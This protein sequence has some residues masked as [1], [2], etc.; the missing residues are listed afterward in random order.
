[1]APTEPRW[2]YEANAGLTQRL[3]TPMG[4]VYGAI[5]QRRYQSVQPYQSKLPVICIGNFTAG[6]TG[7]TPFTQHLVEKLLANERRPCILTRGYGGRVR[8]VHWVDSAHDTAA[9]VGDEPLLLS[10]TAPVLVSL[11][12]AA[13]AREIE[14]SD[15][16]FTH[17]LMDDGLQN[18][19]LKKTLALAIVDG[20]RGIGNAR[21]M[22]AGPL[23]AP[24]QF[25]FGLADAI[26]VNRGFATSPIQDD[27][28]RVLQ[29]FAGPIF[30]AHIAPIGGQGWLRERPVVAFAGIAAPAHF[31]EMLRAIGA[32]I[33]EARPFGDHHTFTESDAAQLLKSAR[34][35]KAQLVTTEKDFVRLAGI[36]GARAD[37]KQSSRTVTIR[38]QI[39]P[40]NVARFNWFFAEAIGG[41][42]RY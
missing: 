17:I 35:H 32:R 42:R 21:V 27:A 34:Q 9:I 25:Q 6:G 2:W 15:H 7:K 20:R 19:T 37:L 26:I 14:A 8:G 22:P 39:D 28:L 33:A 40:A 30:G 18:P 13:G 10:T 16:G 31:F 4:K 24:L 12:R 36:S 38:M 11:D 5:A 1:M 3:L 41:V 29:S 23:R